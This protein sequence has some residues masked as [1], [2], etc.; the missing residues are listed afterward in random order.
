VITPLLTMVCMPSSVIFVVEPVESACES[1]Q[2][3]RIGF[4]APLFSGVGCG[5]S[6]PKKFDLLKI[7]AKSR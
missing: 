7:W 2:M 5:G 6:P 3:F 1:L 4:Q